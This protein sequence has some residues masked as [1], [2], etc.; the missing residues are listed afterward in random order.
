MSDAAVTALREV[1]FHR[2]ALAESQGLGFDPRALARTLDD[3]WVRLRA[4][5]GSKLRSLSGTSGKEFRLRVDTVR[6]VFSVVRDARDRT[7]AFVPLVAPRDEVYRRAS[8]AD[9]IDHFYET[10]WSRARSEVIASPDGGR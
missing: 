4:T 6:A 9:R 10:S 5:R 3:A 1:R 8:F 7:L 2:K